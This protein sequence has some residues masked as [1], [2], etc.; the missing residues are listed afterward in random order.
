MT[1]SLDRGLRTL[2]LL[3]AE[4][5]G[6]T[7]TELA[8][9]LGSSRPAVY[10][11]VATLGR[12]GLAHRGPDGRIRLGLAVLQLA[13]GVQPL[14]RQAALPILRELAEDVG[15]TAHLTLAEG[16]SALAVAVVE[17]SWT[18]VHVAYRV[19]SRHPL[20]RGAAGRA[21]LAARDGSREY[22]VT[23][24]ELQAGTR[25][26]A[27]AVIGVDASVGVVSL[28]E[29]DASVVGPRVM[30]AAADLGVTVTTTGPYT[31]HFS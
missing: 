20:D 7:V 27:A 25:G 16:T 3:S 10:R 23:E 5:D 18:S 24:G 4:A 12:H 22:V 31:D 15:A 17:P 8:A 11:L 29:L 19:G 2:R 1:E 21:I 13:R 28:T 9:A 6:Y 14:L 26:V 30:R